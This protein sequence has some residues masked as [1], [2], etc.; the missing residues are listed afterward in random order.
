MTNCK[1]TQHLISSLNN[2]W[3]AIQHFFSNNQKTTTKYD[4][5]DLV[6]ITR[7]ARYN[8]YI[9]IYIYSYIYIY[10]L[11]YFFDLFS[12]RKTHTQHD[13]IRST[14][15]IGE[16]SAGRKLLSGLIGSPQGHYGHLQVQLHQPIFNFLVTYEEYSTTH[17]TI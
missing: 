7:W 4:I 16:G 12:N 9:Y 11:L 2:K 15:H 13:E 5:A 6:I 1:Q 10:I 8:I 14:A 3:S 17:T